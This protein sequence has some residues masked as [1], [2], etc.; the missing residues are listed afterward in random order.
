MR[1]FWIF[2][3]F[4]GHF[5]Q[6]HSNREQPSII[7]GYLAMASMGCLWAHGAKKRQP[8]WAR[9]GRSCVPQPLYP[10]RVC[11]Y[12][13]LFWD[14]LGSRSGNPTSGWKYYHPVGNP[15]N[16][17]GNPSTLVG[18]L[19][20]KLPGNPTGGWISFHECGWISYHR[21]GK[22]NHPAWNSIQPAWNSIQPGWKS[23]H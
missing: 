8:I 7:E 17:V 5:D 18:N 13:P 14:R 12:S 20:A 1:F 4:I 9:Y 6:T 23:S 3:A 10:K 2:R 19:V 11:R 16:L 22:S 15:S 21:G